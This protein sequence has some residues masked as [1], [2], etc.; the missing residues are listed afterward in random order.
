MHEE[1][2][3]AA[4]RYAGAAGR[5]EF[6]AQHAGN[7]AAYMKICALLIPK[8]MKIEHFSTVKD[9]TDEKLE[10]GSRCQNLICA[11]NVVAD[12]RHSHVEPATVVE[13]P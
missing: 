3:V 4:H 6:R 7:A 5:P 8:E 9:L 1:G 10:S 2:A 11:R 12:T 13:V